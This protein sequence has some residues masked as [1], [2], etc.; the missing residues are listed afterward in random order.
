M[1]LTAAVQVV[2]G[3]D[4][5]LKQQFLFFVTGSR[6]LPQPHTELLRIELPFVAFNQKDH[7]N[8]LSRLPQVPACYH[9]LGCFCS[10]V[11]YVD[12]FIKSWS[13]SL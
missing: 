3:W 12:C 1:Q 7:A 6:R 10:A 8:M 11:I 4:I 9:E 5:E 2:N 13:L